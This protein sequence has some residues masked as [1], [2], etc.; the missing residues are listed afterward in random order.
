MFTGT[1]D[2]RLV[3]LENG[4]VETIARFGSGPCSKLV[5]NHLAGA[6]MEL[7]SPLKMK[8]PRPSGRHSLL[9]C[10]P[11]LHVCQVVTESHSVW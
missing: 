10:D 1:A 8:N 3:K 2:G 7:L 5:T 6:V 4:E 9:W 11:E